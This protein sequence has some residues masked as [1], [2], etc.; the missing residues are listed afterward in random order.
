MCDVLISMYNV[1]AWENYNYKSNWS[2]RLYKNTPTNNVRLKE[3][4][5]KYNYFKY[6]WDILD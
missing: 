1:N 3:H 2:S 5:N 4:Q 6:A